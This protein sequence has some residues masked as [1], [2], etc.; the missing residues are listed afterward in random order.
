M[1]RWNL[2]KISAPASSA[3]TVEEFKEQ[4]RVG[5]SSP[6]GLLQR[7]LDSAEAYIDGPRGIGVCVQEQEWE[8]ALDEFPSV[9][10]IPLYPVVSIE[11]IQY[12][13]TSGDEQTVDESVY[14]VDTH[15]NP[16]RITEAKDQ[17]WP[18]TADVTN[19]VKV[20]FKA[21]H[22]TVPEDL[23]HAIVMLAAHWHENRET[24]VVGTTAAELPIGVEPILDRYRVGLIA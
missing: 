18:T 20:R 10:R 7:L 6:T 15:S 22:E 13:D 23:R 3:V 1:I 8:L 21:G 4:S 2:K 16:A 12:T 19:A 17:T 9:I 14:R 5:D 24:V 11:S